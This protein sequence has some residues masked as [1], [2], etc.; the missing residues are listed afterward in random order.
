MRRA[1]IQSRQQQRAAKPSS[2]FVFSILVMSA[3]D[4]KALL[5]EMHGRALMTERM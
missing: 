5:G 4:E 2:C 1:V 3:W